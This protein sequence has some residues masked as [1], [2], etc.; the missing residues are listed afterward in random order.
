MADSL[1]SSSSLLP[2][3]PALST[4]DLLDPTFLQNLPDLGPTMDDMLAFDQFLTF[5]EEPKIQQAQGPPTPPPSSPLPTSPMATPS[6]H[7]RP[8]RRLECFNCH[9]T[10]TPL[11]RRTPDRAHSLCNACGLYYKQYNQHRPLHIRQKTPTKKQQAQQATLAA[12]AAVAASFLRP[13]LLAA[14]PAEGCCYSCYPSPQC[15]CGNLLNKIPKVR[16]LAIRK[17]PLEEEED[18]CDNSQLKQSHILSP[19]MDDMRFKILLSTM[20]SQQ[21]HGFL[22][23]LER[24]CK[25][26]RDALRDEQPNAAQ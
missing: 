14:P 21:M 8:V 5:D 2:T 10:K 13:F 3:S 18:G 19:E 23:M 26:V 12:T 25:A 16:P 1:F 4:E 15:Y 6:V 17:R 7:K 20:N 24:R 11:W 9:V 22:E